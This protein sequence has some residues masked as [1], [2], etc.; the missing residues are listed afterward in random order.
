M[1]KK[2]VSTTTA[3]ALFFIVFTVVL[4]GELVVIPSGTIIQ[5]A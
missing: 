5:Q 3:L 1:E 4:I 2:S